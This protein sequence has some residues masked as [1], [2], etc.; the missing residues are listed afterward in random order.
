MMA[1]D[2]GNLL[3]GDSGNNRLGVY[4]SEGKFVKVVGHVEWRFS[5]PQGLVVVDNMVY[6]VFSGGKEG[7]IVK[8]TVQGDTE[9]I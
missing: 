4:T 1:D 2:V 5:S 9:I 6:A 3:L 7:A 8:Y